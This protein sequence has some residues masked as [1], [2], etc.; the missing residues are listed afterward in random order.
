M[1]ENGRRFILDTDGKRLYIKK[2][3]NGND[4]IEYLDGRK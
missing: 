1:D 2:D 3:K 4:Y